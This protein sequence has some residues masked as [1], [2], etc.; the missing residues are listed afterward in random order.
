MA[1]ALS[2]SHVTND[3]TWPPKVLWGSTV[4]YPS[5]SLASL[6]RFVTADENWLIFFDRECKA[7][8]I[9]LVTSLSLRKFRAMM[10]VRSV[11]A[12]VFWDSE[13]FVLT[14]YLE[15]TLHV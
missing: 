10:S 6:S 15:R 4:G 13:G 7:Q 2:N 14:D 3:V 9:C 8:S 12:T 1:Y 5:D 11:M